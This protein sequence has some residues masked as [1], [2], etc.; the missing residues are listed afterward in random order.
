ML[1]SLTG[2]VIDTA[3]D[4]RDDLKVLPRHFTASAVWTAVGLGNWW[5]I[6]LNT[7]SSDVLL[8]DVRFGLT[9]QTS[10]GVP[11]R[12]GTAFPAPPRIL[13]V[14][15]ELPAAIV[16]PTLDA[17]CLDRTN[18]SNPP[19]NWGMTSVQKWGL[20]GD[21]GSGD[22]YDMWEPVKGSTTPAAR[23]APCYRIRPNSR[24]FVGAL[25]VGEFRFANDA[26]ASVQ[27]TWVTLT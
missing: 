26:S 8:T 13:T 20:S 11:N 18:N 27:V 17:F 6:C 5:G 14:Y 16:A 4:F 25:Y 2:S 3:Y 24:F 9:G 19:A 10:V 15:K 22:V 12:P 23:G 21:P 1:D 7:A